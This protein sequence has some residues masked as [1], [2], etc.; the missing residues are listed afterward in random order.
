MKSNN[1]L[2]PVAFH[3]KLNGKVEIKSKVS[4]RSRKN[5]SLAYT[6]G[7]GQAV[8]YIHEHKESVY[9]LTTKNNTIAVIT[10][11]SAVLGLGNVGPEAALPVMEGKSAIFKEFADIN[12]FPIC[13]NTQNIDEIVMII[14]A[15][16]PSVGGINIEDI[17]APRCFEIENRLQD[18]G[19]PVVHDDQHATAII[20]LAALINALKIVKKPISKTK[21]VVVGSGAA[22][23]ATIKLLLLAGAKNIIA[24]DRKGIISQSRKDITGYKK[25]LVKI[26]NPNN[27]EGSLQV[28]AAKSDVLI[29]LSSKGLFTKEIIQSMNNDPIIF[30]MANPDPEVLPKDARRWG[31]N[32]IGT[33]RSDYPNQINN[34]LVFPGLF[35]GLLLARKTRMTD[36]IKVNVAHA[37]ASLVDKP[38]P[39]KFITSIFDKRL[40]PAIVKAVAKS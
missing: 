8:K 36:D 31:V 37:I 6:P 30:A 19:I 4:L 22:G 29:G 12:S 20:T 24:I 1:T 34:A 40:V 9:D 25:D 16:S 3:K 27:E 5:L 10:D 32:I 13:L 21:I 15:I 38:T 11:G 2:D 18:L 28:A 39:R 26:T 35:R 17:S 23:T 33:G 14:Q 7:V